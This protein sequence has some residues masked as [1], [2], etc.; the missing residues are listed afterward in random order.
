MVFWLGSIAHAPARRRSWRPS[1]LSRW[2]SLVRTDA[3]FQKHL[4]PDCL[5]SKRYGGIIHWILFRFL[6]LVPHEQAV[7]TCS[8]QQIRCRPVL[9]ISQPATELWSV[10]ALAFG[11]LV[12]MDIWNPT[13]QVS[14]DEGFKL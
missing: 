2:G 3:R 5:A 7:T 8:S 13:H 4:R 6:L 11:G 10:L 1:H 12:P 9:S 14:V